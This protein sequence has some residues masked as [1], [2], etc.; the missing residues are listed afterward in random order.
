ML[1]EIRA[2]RSG[3]TIG[4]EEDAETEFKSLKRS[5]I[6]A[7]QI[8]RHVKTHA[9]AFVNSNGGKFYLGY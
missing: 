6:P 7:Q 5:Q 9:N 2:L 3:E 8:K 1:D 4:L